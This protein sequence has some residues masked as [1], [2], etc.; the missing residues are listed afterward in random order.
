ME[1]SLADWPNRALLQVMSP[2]ISVKLNKTEVTPIFFHRPSMT[3]IYDSAESTA[4]RPQ[5]FDLDDEQIRGMLASPP[6]TGERSKCRPTTSL[7]LLQRENSV[8]S[9]SRFRVSAGK[10]AA[11]LSHKRMSSQESHS[12]RDGI[13]LAHRAVQ[14]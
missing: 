6:H 5:E 11:I 14:G 1:D 13:P 4:T 9:S 12:A 8:S 2:M 10:L 3:S 7:S